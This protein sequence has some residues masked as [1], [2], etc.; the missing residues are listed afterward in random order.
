MSTASVTSVR[1]VCRSHSSLC[2]IAVRATYS[3]SGTINPGV[4]RQTDDLGRGQGPMR[5]S[6]Q[7]FQANDAVRAQMGDRLIVHL[8]LLVVDRRAQRGRPGHR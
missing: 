3:L 5:R 2:R 6:H 1:P 4:F 7:R 8:Q